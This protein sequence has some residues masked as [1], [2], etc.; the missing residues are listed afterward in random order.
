MRTIKMKSGPVPGKA[1]AIALTLLITS[2]GLGSTAFAASSAHSKTGIQGTVV[3]ATTQTQSSS[4]GFEL[5]YFH[6]E[7][8]SKT[9]AIRLKNGLSASFDFQNGTATL[10]D[11]T[12]HQ[13]TLPLEQVL[14]QA[15]NGNS[16]AAA[17]MYDQ[18]YQSISAAKSD[19]IM[20]HAGPASA[21]ANF[22]QPI[23]GTRNVSP[24]FFFPPPRD[25]GGLGDD[26][27]SLWATPT[28]GDCFPIPG[29]CNEWSGGLSDWGPGGMSNWGWYNLWW[30]SA[31]GDPPPTSQP[32][33]PDGCAPNDIDCI[34]WE[35]DRKNACDELVS[36]NLSQGGMD[37]ATGA[38]CAVAET[39]PT[40]L[41]CLGAFITWGVGLHT[42]HK[43][44]EQCHTPYPGPGH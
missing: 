22:R 6:A 12:G 20:A 27:G 30:G 37:V 10:T 29:S 42:L 36:D 43:H 15:T 35:H 2:I 23:G 16:Q 34:L 5:D 40:A 18:L 17:Q 19:A 28:G 14:L 3:A 38:M 7:R 33:R 21:S 1:K 8:V 31:F 39:P 41:G 25:T 13:T 4:A 44:T 26:D 11:V 24:N 9:Y 32:P